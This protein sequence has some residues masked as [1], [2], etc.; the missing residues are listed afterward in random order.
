[1][2]LHVCVCVRANVCQRLRRNRPL[3]GRTSLKRIRLRKESLAANQMKSHSLKRRSGI[4]L[5]VCYQCNTQW[6][7][8]GIR[9]IH[10]PRQLGH[11]SAN[12]W[13]GLF[14]CI[15]RAEQQHLPLNAHY[16]AEMLLIICILILLLIIRTNFLFRWLS[17]LSFLYGMFD[18]VASNVLL[19]WKKETSWMK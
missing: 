6:H 4:N 15:W 1:M 9:T 19:Q 2:Y 13:P 10:F 16:R 8:F 11:T 3:R 14:S 12:V 5:S 18:N 17:V 7:S